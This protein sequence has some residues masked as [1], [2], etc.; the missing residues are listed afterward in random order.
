M[1]LG[2]QVGLCPDKI[3]L[4]GTQLPLPKGGRSPQFLAHICGQMAAGIKMPLGMEVGLD[5]GNFV[6]D[7]DPATLPKKGVDPQIFGPCL[8]SLILAIWGV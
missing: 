1:K 4:D 6:L 7:G 8:L 3:V 2:M 5:P